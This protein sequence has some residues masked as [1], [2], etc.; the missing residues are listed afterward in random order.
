MLSFSFGWVLAQTNAK[1][2]VWNSEVWLCQTC[3]NKVVL[4]WISNKHFRSKDFC[5]L[6]LNW[7]C[8]WRTGKCPFFVPSAPS[9]PTIVILMGGKTK[10]EKMRHYPLVLTH[11]VIRVMHKEPDY[12][13]ES[14][15]NGI[16][17]K[18]FVTISKIEQ[19]LWLL[20]KRWKCVLTGGKTFM[21]RRVFQS[22][23][24]GPFQMQDCQ[25]HHWQRFLFIQ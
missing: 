24:S 7:I 18:I 15:A 22:Q 6:Y 16:K 23:T 21:A 17:K 1:R 12:S 14:C 9:N 25:F 19:W 8:F 3:L 5:I 11:V 4:S 13:L 10:T 20:E 2:W